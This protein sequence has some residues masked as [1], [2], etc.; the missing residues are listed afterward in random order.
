MFQHSDSRALIAEGLISFSPGPPSDPQ[1]ASRTFY[2]SPATAAQHPLRGPVK[3]SPPIGSTGTASIRY[4]VHQPPL[5]G[6]VW[7]DV[8]RGRS[9]VE[10]RRAI[11]DLWRGSVLQGTLTGPT[12]FLQREDCLEET[13]D[14]RSKMFYAI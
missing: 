5:L 14:S 7:Q 2:R 8:I 4:A 6:V 12:A 1:Q 10:F 13:T 11:Q 9:K 3:C